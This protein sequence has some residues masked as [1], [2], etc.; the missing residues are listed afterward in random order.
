MTSKEF[1]IWLKGFSKAANSFNIT[2]AQWDL[3]VEELEKVNDGNKPLTVLPT[4]VLTNDGGTGGGLPWVSTATG[5]SV[6]AS[7]NGEY[8]DCTFTTAKNPETLTSDLPGINKEEVI[9][10]DPQFLS[11]KIKQLLID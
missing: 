5:V 3:L 11:M 7:A 1:V 10:S 2:P 4:G 9:P 6:A 8:K